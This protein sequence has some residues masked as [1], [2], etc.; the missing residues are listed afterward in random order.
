MSCRWWYIQSLCNSILRYY[1]HYS[2]IVWQFVDTVCENCD[3]L[4]SVAPG[5]S[6]QVALQHYTPTESLF[7][8][9][10]QHPLPPHCEDRVFNLTETERGRKREPERGSQSELQGGEGQV[11]TNRS[12]QR[13][14]ERREEKVE[15]RRHRQ[16][17]FKLSV[18]LQ[19]C[20]PGLR[21]RQV[22]LPSFC[23]TC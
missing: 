21:V 22:S 14:T 3:K 8:A 2:G 1:C 23:L 19:T 16:Q 11:E 7:I 13:A 6:Q 12:K 18:Q 5:S 15:K 4:L 20:P 10:Q 17:T 9:W